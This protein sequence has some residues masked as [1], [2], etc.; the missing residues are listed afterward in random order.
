MSGLLCSSPNILGFCL[1]LLLGSGPWVLHSKGQ[2]QVSDRRTIIL[3][4]GSSW[5]HCKMHLHQ[6]DGSLLH[7]CC[8]SVACMAGSARLT[9]RLHLSLAHLLSNAV[10]PS[11]L[12]LVILDCSGHARHFFT[13]LL[14]RGF[15]N[16]KR[17]DG[18]AQSCQQACRFAGGSA[19]ITTL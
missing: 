14:L 5:A 1:N 17:G 9:M 2:L 3:G 16:L 12:P 13:L 18:S 15:R 7:E 11:A 6:A 4:S 19:G 10:S 8:M